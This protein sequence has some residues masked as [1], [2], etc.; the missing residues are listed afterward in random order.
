M[1]AKR[2]TV[3]RASAVAA[4]AVVLAASAECATNPNT[5]RPNAIAEHL[6]QPKADRL[7]NAAKASNILLSVPTENS[8]KIIRAKNIVFLIRGCT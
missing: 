3:I 7:N 1:S 8:E 2:H 6:F 4:S 5:D